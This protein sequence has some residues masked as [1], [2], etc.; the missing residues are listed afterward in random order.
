MERFNKASSIIEMLKQHGHEAYFVGGSVR[1]LIIDRPIGDIDI[2]TSALPEEVMAIFPRHVPVGLE[3]GTVIVVEN[4]EPYEVTTF[5]TESEYEDFRRPSSVQFVRS[6]EEDL[7]RRDFT[8]N[9]IAMTEEGEMVD[10]F[11]GKEA[12]RLKE[13]TTVGDAA[14]RFQEDALRMMRGIRFVSTLGF[15]LEIKTKQAIE[16]YGHL[17]EHIAIERITVE[18]EKLL[19]GTY[20][21][22]GLQELVE[23]KLF[24]HLPYLQMSEERLLKATQYKW[25]SFETDVEAW[26]FFLYCIGEEHPSVFLRQWKFSNKKIKDIVAVLLAIRSRKEKEWDTILLYKT[27]IRIA[28]MAER[29]YEAIIESYNSASVKQVQ[30]LFHAL[31]IKNRQEMNVTGNDL[32]SW[33]DKKPGPWVA[34][35]LQNIEEAIVQGDLVNKKEDIREWLQRCNLL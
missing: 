22:N 4:G 11:A 16:T 32:L 20:C 2:A 1:D 25:D 27:G 19:T 35:M 15:S 34:E 6:L 26:A 33:T 29:V 10:L 14:D 13:I 31:P 28:E 3:H 5:R 24:S 9:A 12:I 17:L 30:S 23:T 21:V 7:K 8:M 18:F